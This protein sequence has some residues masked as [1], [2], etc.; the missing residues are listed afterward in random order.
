LRSAFSRAAAVL[1]LAGFLAAFTGCEDTQKVNEPAAPEEPTGPQDPALE[2]LSFANSVLWGTTVNGEINLSGEPNSEVHWEIFN[3]AGVGSFLPT[4]NTVTLDADG[5]ATDQFQYVAP[6]TTGTYGYDYEITQGDLIGFGELDIQVGRADAT[7][8]NDGTYFDYNP[9]V[10]LAEASN[11][12]AS[13]ESKGYDVQTFLSNTATEID[14]AILG[15]AALVIP[16][17]VFGGN[18]PATFSQTARDKI[19]NFVSN[20]GLLLIA[21]D[22][23]YARQFL[24]D[25]FGWSPDLG[26]DFC[27]A[28]ITLQVPGEA[29]GTP[30]E[31][32]T[33]NMTDYSICYAIDSG[34][35]PAGGKRIY[36]DGLGRTVVTY[37]AQGTGAVLL[38]GWTWGNAQPE[39]PLNT[40]WVDLLGWAMQAAEAEAY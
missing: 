34:F 4:N 5:L 16:S 13:I 15:K 28:T 26:T 6:Q 1:M 20:G 17:N 7:M 19:T 18:F 36:I 2:S 14:A 31:M 39:G 10:A 23:Y 21:D 8:W 25:L 32:N 27:N 33:T 29:A 40:G 11:L 9:G 38:L 24:S 37:V 22:G 30:F 12:E 35:L 3:S